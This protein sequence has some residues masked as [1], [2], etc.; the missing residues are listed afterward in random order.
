MTYELKGVEYIPDS[1]GIAQEVKCPLIDDW[2][3]AG[4]C[5][6]NQGPAEQYIPARFKVKA[7]WK[8]ICES[9]PFRDY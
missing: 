3:E 8:E 6:S 4:D 5:Q 7:N 1:D 9:C 2:I